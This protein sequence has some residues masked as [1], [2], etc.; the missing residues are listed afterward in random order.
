MVVRDAVAE[1]LAAVMTPLLVRSIVATLPS[2]SEGE[3]GSLDMMAGYDLLRYVADGARIFSGPPSVD[4]LTTLHDLIGGSQSFRPSAQVLTVTSDHDVIAAQD[5]ARRLVRALFK[6]T[7]CVR[8]VTAVSELARNIYMYAGTGEVRLN[9][10]EADRT[11]TFQVIASDR[12]PG[13]ARLEE[14]LAG[15]YHSRSGLGRG[16][17][18]A[19][20][21]LEGLEIQ[22]GPQ[23]TTIK[24]VK[25]ARFADIMRVS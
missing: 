1:A 7:D 22:T 5:A 18:G 24:G 14:I 17:L 11:I 6:P 19:K 10:S 23:G 16:L 2:S 25:Q 21:L 8:V 12:G 3:V 13:I 15:T 9:V 4:L 20:T